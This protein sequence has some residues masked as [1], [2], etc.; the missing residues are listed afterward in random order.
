MLG[1]DVFVFCFLMIGFVGLIEW[2]NVIILNVV[3]YKVI[4]VISEGF[5]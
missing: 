2:E 5:E 4:K 1:V 3:L